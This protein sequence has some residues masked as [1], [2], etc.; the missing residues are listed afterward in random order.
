VRRQRAK[1]QKAETKQAETKQA[2]TEQYEG[3]SAQE[4]K[5]QCRAHPVHESEVKR[6]W[7]FE[8]TKRMVMPGVYGDG[9]RS[10]RYVVDVSKKSSH[11]KDKEWTDINDY[12]K[13]FKQPE[14]LGIPPFKDLSA[15][16]TAGID[17]IAS[18]NDQWRRRL[19]FKAQE[20]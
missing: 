10:L 2:G 6:P 5:R 11:F 9:M 1:K 8:S 7:I 20:G 3:G 17:M 14:L 15:L 19:G 16:Y 13:P 12:L 4:S 18:P